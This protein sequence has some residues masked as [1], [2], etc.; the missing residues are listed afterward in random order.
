MKRLLTV[1]AIVLIGMFMVSTAQAAPIPHTYYNVLGLGPGQDGDAYLHVGSPPNPYNGDSTYV[2]TDGGGA[3]HVVAIDSNSLSILNNSNSSVNL[4]DPVWLLLMVPDV[5]SSYIA[6]VITD[7]SLGTVLGGPVFATQLN[8]ADY[9]KIYVDVFDINGDASFSFVN[10]NEVNTEVNGITADHYNIY[11]YK[12]DMPT[13]DLMQKHQIDLTFGKD[14]ELGT[15]AAAVGWDPVKQKYATTPFTEA[16]L[17]R[18]VP[19]PSSFLLIGMGLIG[20]GLFRR[21]K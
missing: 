21:K 11:V 10:M 16:G 17:Y 1:L 4:V 9:K 2:W 15:F 7:I 20:M 18:R 3:G 12:F 19:E 13:N 6:P 14:L 8:G 5:D